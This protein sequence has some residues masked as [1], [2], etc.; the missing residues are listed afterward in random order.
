MTWTAPRLA[1]AILWLALVAYVV[2]APRVRFLHLRPILTDREPVVFDVQLDRQEDDRVLVIAAS[3]GEG[4]IRRTDVQID[5]FALRTTRIAWQALPAG[6]LTVTAAI[7]GVRGEV[8]RES[9][10]LL[11]RGLM[12]TT[13]A[14]EP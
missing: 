12:E 14:D 2:A 9:R 7:I 1:N 13:E 6:H 11:V 10:P 5:R 4:V 3:D 8:A